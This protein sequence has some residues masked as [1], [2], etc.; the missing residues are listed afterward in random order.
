MT[1]PGS[2]PLL[3]RRDRSASG[4]VDPGQL[5]LSLRGVGADVPSSGDSFCSAVLHRWRC[6]LGSALL[7]RFH[8]PT[9]RL[10]ARSGDFR[11]RTEQARRRADF[12]VPRRM[13]CGSFW[14]P[15]LDDDWNIDGGGS[16]GRTGLDLKPWP[17]LF[18][19]P[20]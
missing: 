3:H 11:K 15:S 2:E 10:D 6:P 17:V 16:A 13:G 14:A 12:R 8:G 19:L 20:V 5:P 7:L 4:Q 1:E 18:F 9:V